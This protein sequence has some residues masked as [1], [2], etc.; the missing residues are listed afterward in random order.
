[1]V[2]CMYIQKIST[3]FYVADDSILDFLS[4]HIDELNERLEKKGYNVTAKMTVK[5]S[6]ESKEDPFSD[7]ADGGGI[8]G[9]LSQTGTLKLA[10]YSFDVRT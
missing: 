2:I 8:N 10:E 6:P 1:M 5:G 7:A 3:R 9:I 4:S